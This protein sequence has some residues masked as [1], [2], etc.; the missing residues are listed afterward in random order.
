MSDPTSDYFAQTDSP[1]L[2]PSERAAGRLALQARMA[3]TLTSEEKTDIRRALQHVVYAEPAPASA[4]SL[5]RLPVRLPAMAF[6]VLLLLGASGG[7]LT[8]A[9]ESALPGD[10]LYGVK[11]HV[12]EAIRGKFQVTH[13]DR[14]RWAVV[15]LQRRMD[16]LRGLKA[17]GSAD[18]DIDVAM[19]DHLETAATDVQ[20]EV[21]ALPA[22]AAERAAMRTAVNAA[23]GTDQDSLRRASKINR[24]LKALKERAEG[25]DAPPE[26]TIVAPAA[27]AKVN[28]DVDGPLRVNLGGTASASIDGTASSKARSSARADASSVRRSSA[29]ASSAVGTEPPAASVLPTNDPASEPTDPDLPIPVVDAPIDTPEVD[30][31][32]LPTQGAVDGLL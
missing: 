28:V 32:D 7:G 13:E 5:F 3:L 20:A 8:Y 11:I 24:V 17:R 25:F 9:A 4:W 31:P 12:N 26:G 22:A 6:A 15:R 1:V 29:P 14:A 2:T 30:V 23:I 16:E 27:G 21:D 18:E 10:A 19:G